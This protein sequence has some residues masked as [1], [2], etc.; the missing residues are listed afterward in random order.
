MTIVKS[1]LA[2]FCAAFLALGASTMQT[3]KAQLKSAGPLAFGP[4]GVLFVGDSAGAAI[5]A[6]DVNDRTPAKSADGLEIKGI[7]EKIAAMLGT[8]PDQIVINDVA[9]NPISK[10]ALEWLRELR[11]KGKIT[12]DNYEGRMRY[13]RKKA[14]A[15]YAQ[16]SARICFASYHVAMHEDAA[17]TS[18]MLGHQSPA[19]LWNTYRALVTKS[20]AKRY[21]KITPD[22]TGEEKPTKV[23]THDEAK[24]A[25][26]KRVQAALAEA[27][28]TKS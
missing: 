7:N 9:V 18:V 11:G 20:E 13:L 8:A 6:L 4:D 12:P 2:L 28:S 5:V 10:N 15:G 23:I 14:K 24:A 21:W 16:N 22:Y 3:G 19:L 27:T 25:R 1:S 26:R 17:K